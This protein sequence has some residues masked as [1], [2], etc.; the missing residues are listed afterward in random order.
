MRDLTR[1]IRHLLHRDEFAHELDEEM[2]LHVE[3][4]ARRLREQGIP[5]S[6]VPPR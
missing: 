2:Q 3:L 1:R 5:V 4:R 6:A